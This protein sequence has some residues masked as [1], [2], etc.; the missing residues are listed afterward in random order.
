MIAPTLR[1]IW[2]ML[3]GL[4]VLLLIAVIDFLTGRPDFLDLGLVYAL[5]NFIGVIAV[6]R[7]FKLGRFSDADPEEGE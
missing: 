6:L 5:I 2:A 3:L 1:A 4:P 7:F